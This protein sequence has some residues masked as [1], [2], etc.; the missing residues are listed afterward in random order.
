MLSY[1]ESL[2]RRLHHIII[3]Q[4]FIN[5]KPGGAESYQICHWLITQYLDRQDS[6]VTVSGIARECWPVGAEGSLTSN[7]DRD[8]H[9]ILLLFNNKE[10]II[11][12]LF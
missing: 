1:R 8:I 4:V 12:Y 9:F 3:C 11:L 2:H 5:K 10:K 7:D 6:S